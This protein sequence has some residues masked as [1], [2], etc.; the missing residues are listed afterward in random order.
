MARCVDQMAAVKAVV[1]AQGLTPATTTA[2]A[3]PVSQTVMIRRA[4]MT[5]A[6][7]CVVFAEKAKAAQ[8]KGSALAPHR[9]QTLV[10]ALVKVASVT[11]SA[12]TPAIAATTSAA[13]ALTTLP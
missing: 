4:A 6:A 2:N 13:C 7:A 5:V 10:V 1:N 3:K 9:V 11:S 8:T 12:S